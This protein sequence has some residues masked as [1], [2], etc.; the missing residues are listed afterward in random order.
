MLPCKLDSIGNGTHGDMPGNDSQRDAEPD[1]KRNN[2]I[3][4]VAVKNKS[5][6]PPAGEEQ[7]EEDV[8]YDTTRAIIKATEAALVNI[9]RLVV[10]KG[11]KAG[12]AF[13][14][15]AVVGRS[16]S[17]FRVSVQVFNGST[18]AIDDVIGTAG[19]DARRVVK[20]RV[21]M[22]VL[23]LESGIGI[24]SHS[25]RR[26]VGCLVG[27]IGA[28]GVFAHDGQRLEDVLQPS[29]TT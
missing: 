27:G 3:H 2:P 24:A 15:V 28:R 4:V 7:E 8:D 20:V 26:L 21:V 6:N 12:L 16:S 22:L 11:Q 19:V 9:L 13:F 14:M 1:E 18:L 29:F 5:G 10:W 25:R 23:R 17:L